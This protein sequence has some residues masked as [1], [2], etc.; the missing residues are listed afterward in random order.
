[1]QKVPVGK[2]R[3]GA[4]RRPAS[5]FLSHK[6]YHNV[7]RLCALQIQVYSTERN[8]V[9]RVTAWI[10]ELEW[11][12]AKSTVSCGLSSM[13]KTCYAWRIL[14]YVPAMEWHT[15]SVIS[16]YE[17]DQHLVGTIVSMASNVGKCRV[18]CKSRIWDCREVSKVVFGNANTISRMILIS[19]LESRPSFALDCFSQT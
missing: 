12:K 1:M 9:I 17:I 11:Y 10:L 16:D 7:R 19:N 5:R 18:Q 4:G 8:E 3:R 13:V 2:R 6:E 15:E 14:G